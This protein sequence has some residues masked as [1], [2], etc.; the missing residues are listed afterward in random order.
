MTYFLLIVTVFLSMSQSI[1]KKEFTKR[2]SSGI[3]SFTALACL[4]ALPVFLLT[5][6]GFVLSWRLIA[7]SLGFSVA[8]L[9]ASVLGT[10]ALRYGSF[11]TTTLIFSYSTLIPTVYGIVALGEVPT[12]M[13]YIGF[14]LLVFSLFLTNYQKDKKAQETTLAKERRHS[15][16][17]LWFVFL[18]LSFLGNGMCSTVQKI[19][20][21]DPLLGEGQTAAF[22]VVALTVNTVV[23]AIVS[24]VAEKPKVIKQALS[25]TWLIAVLSGLLNGLLNF[26][27]IYL[28]GR[29]PASVLFP[30]ISGGGVVLTFLYA[31]A[32]YRERFKLW[33]TVGF[34]LGIA[35]IIC[36]NL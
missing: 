30:V 7:Y 4:S 2:C 32:V 11:A 12:T 20:S 1:F 35:S 14:V 22:M 36:L 15:D 8:Y 24:L 9:L 6:D 26:L 3:F 19:A 25:R 10:L 34:V 13:M 31:I 28:N 21:A 23:M 16:T 18:L 27:V 33:Q 5:L 17:F 29:L